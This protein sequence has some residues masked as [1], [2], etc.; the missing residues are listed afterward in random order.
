MSHHHPGLRLATGAKHL[1]L[2][3]HD[4]EKAGK[5][6]A[7][8]DFVR[9]CSGWSCLTW[10]PKLGIGF[11][12]AVVSLVLLVLWCYCC[13]RA[14]ATR[15]ARNTIVLP[16]GRRVFC[17]QEQS[18]NVVCTEVLPVVQQWPGYPARVVYYPAVFRM[19][20][21]NDPRATA[22]ILPYSRGVVH[23]VIGSVPL[24]Q[25]PSGAASPSTR[26][27]GTTWAASSLGQQ[28][29]GQALMRLLRTPVGTASTVASTSSRATS[30]GSR[31]SP[32]DLGP[33]DVD[34]DANSVHT[35]AATVDSDDFQIAAQS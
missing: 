17:R 27:D 14:L 16:G 26:A 12:I 9:R 29:W 21:F 2:L 18:R 33:G 24:V 28:T 1:L 15:Q 31:G 23:P 30:R 22:T 20:H 7:G 8:Q 32:V 6:M 3:I 25:Q 35:N 13:G 11:G 10:T 19:D 4:T 5:D 34:G